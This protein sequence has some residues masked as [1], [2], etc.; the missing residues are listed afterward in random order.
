MAAKSGSEWILL[1]GKAVLSTEPRPSRSRLSRLLGFDDLLVLSG[2]LKAVDFKGFVNNLKEGWVVHELHRNINVR[3]TQEGASN[4]TWTFLGVR[5]SKTNKW[6]SQFSVMGYGAQVSSLMSSPEWQDIDDRLIENKP[7]SF[8]GLNGLFR[9]LHL[10]T[11]RD[12]LSTRMV[13]IFDRTIQRQIAYDV[14][15]LCKTTN[16]RSCWPMLQVW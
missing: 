6:K 4:C 12:V 7:T 14:R 5:P 8:G 13:K 1:C 11:A 16:G 15:S 2:R 3:I 9:F 10:N